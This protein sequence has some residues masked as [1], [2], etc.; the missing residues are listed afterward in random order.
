MFG[1][2][3][4]ETII[5]VAFIFLIASVF[6]STINEGI[7]SCLSLRAKDLESGLKN[8]LA[9][10]ASQAQA[11]PVA[12]ATAA[13][14]GGAVTAAVAFRAKVTGLGMASEILNHPA[15]Q[16]LCAP[17]LFRDEIAKPSYLDAK[18]FSGALFD[19]LLP[20]ANTY[21]FAELRASVQTLDNAELK[22]T[23][24]PL[25][26][27]ASGN[28]DRARGNIEQAFDAMMDRLSGRYKRRAHLI[29][30]A[31]GLVLAMVFNIDT[32][33]AT[34]RLWQEQTVRELVA[35]QATS[36]NAQTKSASEASGEAATL[37]TAYLDK[38]LPIG[39]TAE[40]AKDWPSPTMILGWILTAIAVSFGAPFWFDF[41]NKTL[42]LNARLAGNKPK[43]SDTNG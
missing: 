41:L 4:L 30:L 19:L 17:K 32:V 8:F 9:E 31:I 43:A 23:L 36:F 42:G 3:V 37:E 34:Q 28:I 10:P 24:L 1:S 35:S 39:W 13:T 20:D 26:D 15:V 11:A 5:G 14:A 2:H 6:A 29:I 21:S 38:S 16:N 25:I 7:A 33:R 27:R 12:V 18:T 40:A 22:S